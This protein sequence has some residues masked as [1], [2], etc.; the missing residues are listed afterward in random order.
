MRLPH[1]TLT[2]EAGASPTVYVDGVLYTGQ[3]LA[4]GSH[5][6]TAT[7]TDAAGNVS[8]LATAARPLIISTSG[9]LQATLTVD[10]GAAITN[11]RALSLLFAVTDPSPAATITITANG[12]VVYSGAYS[13]TPAASL[14]GADGL[15]AIVATITDQAGNTISLSRT[16][17]LDTTGPAVSASLGAPTN[18]TYYDVGATLALTW[19]ASDANGLISSGAKLD[20][21]TISSNRID[22]DS[23]AAGLHTVT[24]NAIDAAGNLTTMTLTFT[25]RPT[26][27]GILAAINDGFAR[28]FMTAA[29]K[30]TLVSAINNVIGANNVAP[31]LRGFI[32]Q[33]Q[34]ATAAQLS[35][36]FQA[37]LLSWAND[38]LSRS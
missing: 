14:V 9:S 16:I 28:G 24:V 25:I 8:A 5:T 10:G 18:G 11:Q 17:R 3:V 26:A 20:G 12:T 33:V 37:L 6:V 38:L 36:A 22:L 19:T 13:N 35:A 2:G 29:E 31:K 15:Y 4:A 23:L 21:Q 34:S 7:L 1:F 32:S 30:A 27:S